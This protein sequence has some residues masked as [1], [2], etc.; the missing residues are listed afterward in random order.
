MNDMFDQ[1]D[2]TIEVPHVVPYPEFVG[3]SHERRR[4]WDLA[5][6]VAARA[7]DEPG[8]SRYVMFAARHLFHD[9]TLTT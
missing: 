4:R 2:E 5:V 7:L 6:A 1:S 8:D 9:E 3:E